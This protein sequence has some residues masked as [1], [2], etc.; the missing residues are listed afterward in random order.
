MVLQQRAPQEHMAHPLEHQ[1][2]VVAADVLQE[3]IVELQQRH[4]RLLVCL[5][6]RELITM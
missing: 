3:H 1:H 6:W 4:P 2:S 5:V